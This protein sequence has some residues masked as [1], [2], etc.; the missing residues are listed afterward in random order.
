[1]IIPANVDPNLFGHLCV[2]YIEVSEPDIWGENGNPTGSSSDSEITIQFGLP[3]IMNRFMQKRFNIFY[4]MDEP[5]SY[6][7][8]IPYREAEFV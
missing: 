7:H 8:F 3:T 5:H 6:D 2:D 4:I 1:M